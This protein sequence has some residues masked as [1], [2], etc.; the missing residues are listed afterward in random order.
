[1]AKKRLFLL[2]GSAMVYR[3]FF[4]FLQNPLVNSKGENTSATF[5]FLLSLFKIQDDEKPDG[6]AVVFDTPEPTFRH[7]LFPEYR[8]L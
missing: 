5:G 8:L 7:N 6:L 4:A 2:D 1:M 3:A